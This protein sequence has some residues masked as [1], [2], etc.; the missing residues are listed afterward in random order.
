MRFDIILL[1]VA[2]QSFLG[3]CIP[4][5]HKHAEHLSQRPRTLLHRHDSPRNLQTL[6]RN[7]MRM[8]TNVIS[9]GTLTTTTSYSVLTFIAKAMDVSKQF[10]IS[11]IK[12]SP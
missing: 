7:Q 2:L 6:T 8:T 4:A 12:V 11:R 10:L 9:L 5:G 3:F 1:V